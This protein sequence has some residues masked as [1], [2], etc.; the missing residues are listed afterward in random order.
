MAIYRRMFRGLFWKDVGYVFRR[1][2]RFPSTSDVYLRKIVC[3]SLVPLNID[4]ILPEVTFRQ[5]GQ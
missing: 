1:I 3:R 4:G 5:I 2:W